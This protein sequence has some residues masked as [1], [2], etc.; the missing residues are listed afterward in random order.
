M[1]ESS[2]EAMSSAEGVG[3]LCVSKKE[4]W[5]KWQEVPTSLYVSAKEKEVTLYSHLPHFVFFIPPANAVSQVFCFFLG[6]M[7]QQVSPAS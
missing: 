5:Q 6:M 1:D 3:G 4:R 2:T 7:W